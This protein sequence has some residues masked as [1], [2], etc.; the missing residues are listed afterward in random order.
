MTAGTQGG[1]SSGSIRLSS[2]ISPPPATSDDM[3]L[4]G[5]GVVDQTD[6][7]CP[8]Q[9]GA[10]SGCMCRKVSFKDASWVKSGQSSGEMFNA[11]AGYHRAMC[12]TLSCS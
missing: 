6:H 5:I 2:A 8:G 7:D 4:C 3:G 9:A 12:T 11:S 1:A 10:A